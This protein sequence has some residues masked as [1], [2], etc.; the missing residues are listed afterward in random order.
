MLDSAIEQ[1]WR[2]VKESYPDA[3]VFHELSGL[4]VV[5]G[6]DLAVLTKEFGIESASSWCGFD[7]SQAVGYMQELVARGYPVVRAT[8]QHVA[9]V[10]PPEKRRSEVL[11]QRAKGCFLALS[12][13]LLFEADEIE[14]STPNAWMKRHG[15]EELLDI[16][17][18]WLTGE[19][20]RS[21]RQHGEIYVY[22]VGDWY[23]VDV[24]LSSMLESHVLL[25]AK[26]ALATGRN[27]PCKLVEP[28]SRRKRNHRGAAHAVPTAAPMTRLGQVR[29]EGW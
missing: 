16:F 14:R 23:E 4:F 29:F 22:Q 15:Y 19:E 9:I 6:H 10:S 5:R 7:D 24:E 13:T 8:G 25:L 28:P 11:R 12:P 18:A 20:L 2:T 3:V 26:A 1:S 27:M 21:L 17:K